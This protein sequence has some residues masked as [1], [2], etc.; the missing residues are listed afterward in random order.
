MN[1]WMS[2]LLAASGPEAL[3]I[4]DKG[5]NMVAQSTAAASVVMKKSDER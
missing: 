4:L 1:E 5:K 2:S 3:G